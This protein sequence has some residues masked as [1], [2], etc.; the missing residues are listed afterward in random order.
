[1]R[2]VINGCKAL[3]VILAG[4]AWAFPT[5]SWGQGFPTKPVRYVVPFGAGASPDI[6]ARTLSERFTKIWGQQVLVENR[7]GA[8]GT[9]GAAFVAKSPPDGY[10][11]FQCNI[12]SSAIAESLYAKP[13]Y[14]H[15][16]D[17]API[18]RIGSTPNALFVHPSTPLKSFKEFIAYAKANPGRLSY[19]S[20]AAGTSPQLTMELLKLLG[21]LNIVHVPYKDAPQAVSDVIGGQIPVG[22]TNV[23]AVLPPL[24]SGR[25]RGLAVTSLTRVSQ[26]PNVPTVHES[27]FPDFEVTAWYGVCAPSGTPTALLDKLHTDVT[28]VLRMPEVQQRLKDLMIEVA[29]TSRE[30]FAQIIRTETARWAKVIKDA[31]ITAQ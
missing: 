1:M 26:L 29:P 28:T 6:V 13:G 2:V 7:S 30:E 19:G 14:N 3:V 17:F 8:G 15:Q 12:A 21:K 11:L 4:L 31:G 9:M 23:P 24:Q 10:T 25:L 18:S 16:R 20:S 22:I 27:G 5:G